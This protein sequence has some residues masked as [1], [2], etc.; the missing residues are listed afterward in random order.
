M[1]ST[2]GPPS[3][4]L[5]EAERSNRCVMMV[6]QAWDEADKVEQQRDNNVAVQ[7]VLTW[8]LSTTHQQ[9]GTNMLFLMLYLRC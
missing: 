6:A 3:E 5:A 2:V 8:S 9:G 4:R 1:Q 7:P